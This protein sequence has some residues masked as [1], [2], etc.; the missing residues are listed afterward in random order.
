MKH[1]LYQ[2]EKKPVENHQPN[3]QASACPIQFLTDLEA[4]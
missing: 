2:M 4:N 3:M 1:Q